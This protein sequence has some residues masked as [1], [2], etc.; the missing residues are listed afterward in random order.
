[1]KILKIIIRTVSLLFLAGII[2][3]TWYAWKVFPLIS[4][5]GS[6]NMCS[7]VYLQHRDPKDILREDLG[8]FPESLGTFTVNKDDS[9]VTGTSVNSGLGLLARSIRRVE[10]LILS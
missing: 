7:A 9:S 5:Y 4:G 6:K 3:G 10:S 2:G 8:S 1:M